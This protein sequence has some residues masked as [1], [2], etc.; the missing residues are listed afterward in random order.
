M[1]N[2][3][4]NIQCYG[5]KEK[6]AAYALKKS[7]FLTELSNVCT[8]IV[9]EHLITE[10][11]IGNLQLQQHGRMSTW[12]ITNANI[13]IQPKQYQLT[14]IIHCVPGLNPKHGQLLCC[15]SSTVLCSKN[16]SSWIQLDRCLCWQVAVVKECLFTFVSTTVTRRIYI[17][18]W[19]THLRSVHQVHLQQ[20]GLQWSLGRTV[21]LQSIEEERR[22][23][24]NHVCLHEHIDNLHRTHRH[25]QDGSASN[26]LHQPLWKSVGVEL[27]PF[28]TRLCSDQQFHCWK[29]RIHNEV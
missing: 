9:S 11:S 4:K 5:E 22:T 27:Y 24:L 16:R 17:L 20:P 21:V 10:Y 6:L 8:I 15:D 14:G 18:P 2:G 29:T 13:T 28:S 3:S 25:Y 12:N 7:G 1:K 19:W 26:I 23:R